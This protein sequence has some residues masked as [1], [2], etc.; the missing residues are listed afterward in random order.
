MIETPPYFSHPLHAESADVLNTGLPGTEIS[1]RHIW[2]VGG[3]SNGTSNFFSFL[4]FLKK[5]SHQWRHCSCIY[6]W[7]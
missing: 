2:A 4:F 6:L 7:E 3:V 5:S 1:E